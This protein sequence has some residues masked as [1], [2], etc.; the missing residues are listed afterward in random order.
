VYKVGGLDPRYSLAQ[1][2]SFGRI[3]ERAKSADRSASFSADIRRGVPP[4]N[5]SAQ[6]SNVG[7]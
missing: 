4:L 7:H 2:R 5:A 1:L 6:V 3:T